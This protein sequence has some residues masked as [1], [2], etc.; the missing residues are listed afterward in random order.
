MEYFCE[1]IYVL[2]Y[3]DAESCIAV[4]YNTKINRKYA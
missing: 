1:D 4:G 3:F 2:G